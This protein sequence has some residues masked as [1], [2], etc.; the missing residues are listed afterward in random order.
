MLYP[1]PPRPDPAQGL[2]QPEHLLTEPEQLVLVLHDRIWRCARRA[3]A[4]A[5]GELRARRAVIPR[6][7][8]ALKPPLP[9]QTFLIVGQQSGRPV[10]SPGE[11]ARAGEI[12]GTKREERNDVQ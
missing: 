5:F 3:P 11:A 10:D 7:A 6:V 1:V 4:A 12:G 8:T 2:L 9:G